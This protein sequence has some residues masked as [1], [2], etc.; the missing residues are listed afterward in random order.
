MVATGCLVGAVANAELTLTVLGTFAANEPSLSRATLHDRESQQ[1]LVVGVG[2]EIGGQALV[3]AIERERVVLREHGALRE[4]TLEGA[5]QA[6][7]HVVVPGR[8]DRFARSGSERTIFDRLL[9]QGQVLPKFE[10]GQMIGL[11]VSAIQAGG[12][13][14]EIGLENGD[15]ITEFNGDPIDSQAKTAK[16]LQQMSEEDAYRVVALRADGS[17]R[18]W[19]FVRAD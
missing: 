17:E 7:A 10:D 12:L 3:V 18:F 11:Q 16:V 19:D 1:T 8:D 5:G 6:R 4:L 15:V 2:D 13:Y 14:D 9:G